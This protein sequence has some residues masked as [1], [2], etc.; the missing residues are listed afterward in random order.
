M[1]PTISNIDS[2]IA[3]KIKSYPNDLLKASQLNTWVRVFSGAVSGDNEGLIMESNTDFKLFSAAGEAGGS[4]YGNPQQSGTLGR[5]WNGKAVNVGI[6]RGFRPSPIIT[7]LTSKE[8]KNQISRTCDFSITCYS[9]QQLE[10][11]QTYFME[12]G[13]S[14]GVEWGWNSRNG[15]SGLISTK[16]G[17]ESILNGIAD[18]TLNNGELSNKR[19]KTYGE[20]DVFLGFIVGSSISNDGE[21]YKIDVKL[22]GAPS[23]P[24]YLQSQNRIKTKAEDREID[25]N[26]VEPFD[27]TELTKVGEN[28]SAKR[29]FRL[30][31]NSL[32]QTRRISQIKNKISTA[33][34]SDFVNMDKYISN[35]INGWVDETKYLGLT[36]EKTSTVKINNFDVELEREKLFSD[37]KYIRFEF[38]IDILNETGGLTEYSIGDKKLSFK[39]NIKKCVIGAFPNMYSTKASKLLIA[40]TMPSFSNYFLAGSEITQL[41][42]GSLKISNTTI[43]PTATSNPPLIPFVE[44]KDL[45]LEVGTANKSSQKKLKLKEKRGYYGYIKNLYINFD[46]F[47]EKIQ[48]PNKT[49][50]EVLLDI[51]NEMSSAVNGFWNFQIVETEADDGNIEITIIDE[52]W[53][54]EN[55]EPGAV[56]EFEHT[57][58]KSPFLN[59]NLD[60]S[61]P[62]NLTNK[63][64]MERLQMTSQPD[65]KNLSVG[66]TTLFNSKTDLFIE[67][68][69]FS[70]GSVDIQPKIDDTDG[71]SDNEKKLQKLIDA[72]EQLIV[73]GGTPN[74]Y[75]NQ[76]VIEYK[77][78]SG[79]VIKREFADGSVRYYLDIQRGKDVK[80]DTT[81][82]KLQNAVEKERKNIETQKSKDRVFAYLDLIDII[83]NPKQTSFTGTT[84]K[85]NINVLLNDITSFSDKFSIHCFDDTD[86]FDKIRNNAFENKYGTAKPQSLSQPL[87]ITYT[88]TILGNSGIR[89]GDTFN[90]NGIPKKYKDSG[91]FQVTEIEHSISD[92]KWTT[93]ITGQY[94]Q[95]Q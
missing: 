62:S 75:L 10:Y 48:Q 13:Y 73:G 90:I 11:L 26:K 94:R 46:M 81:I 56:I 25:E 40:G 77:S 30:M 54:G 6:G 34:I 52:N 85:A 80:G 21:N 59:S 82:N 9:L 71:R 5:D 50:T 60:I 7:S 8:G 43:P 12:P 3:E 83:P 32:P 78:A 27:T 57:G 53:I 76:T 72:K 17:V 18:T 61:I 29:R 69:Q 19:L 93:T 84:A 20:Y 66:D 36:K 92:M 79:S 51:L 88:F 70:T 68:T 1:W 22:R 24:T 14:I 23:L 37:N 47:L 2:K 49:I 16:G 38:A 31:F 41:A 65:I 35:Q 4:I 15:V 28:T 33:N 55:P 63:I 64:V 42:D 89:R 74:K 67:R 44:T 87:P 45:N 91:L 86:F 95:I 39:T 58:L